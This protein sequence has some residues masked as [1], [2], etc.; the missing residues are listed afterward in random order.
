ML[1]WDAILKRC[2]LAAIVGILASTVLT[3]KWA[4]FVGIVTLYLLLVAHSKPVNQW[5]PPSD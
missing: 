3:P 1:P 2:S 5:P 4:V